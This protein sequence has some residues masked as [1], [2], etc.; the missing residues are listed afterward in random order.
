MRAGSKRHKK[1]FLFDKS[2]SYRDS[3]RLDR[4]FTSLSNNNACS[5]TIKA[6]CKSLRAVLF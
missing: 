5:V 3:Y 6:T 4:P 2:I 1:M